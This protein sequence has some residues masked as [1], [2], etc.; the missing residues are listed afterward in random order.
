MKWIASIIGYIVGGG[1]LGGVIGYGIGS[2]IDSLVKKEYETD[3]RKQGDFVMSILVLFSAVMKS[4][5]RVLK[6]ELNYVKKWLV[7][8]LGEEDAQNRL[9]ILRELLKKDIDLHQACERINSAIAYSSRLEIL[10]MLFG[11]A[12]ADGDFS[13]AEKDCIKRIANYLLLAPEDYK[14]IEAMYFKD[15][16][17]AYTILQVDRNASDEEIK[18]S[19]RRLCIKYH[20]DKVAHL[21]ESAQKDAEKKFKQINEAYETIKKE[22]N[23]N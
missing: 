9:L 19:Y 4:D 13:E 5:G 8:N 12:L 1:L 17:S 10:H 20:P 21:G 14:T 2:L 15:T 18:K 7:T 23:F 11:I 3:G 16:S 6:S 22:R